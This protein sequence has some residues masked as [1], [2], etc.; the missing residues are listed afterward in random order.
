MRTSILPGPVAIRVIKRTFVVPKPVSLVADVVLR[1]PF[2]DLCLLHRITSTRLLCSGPLVLPSS[3][4]SIAA[5]TMLATPI[6]PRQL[7]LASNSTRIVLR[8]CGPGERGI[9][10]ILAVPRL[11]LPVDRTVSCFVSGAW[12]ARV[13]KEIL[14][15]RS[16]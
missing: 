10:S 5:H 13:L 16:F 4:E 2:P 14:L 15:V 8:G 7:L 12:R 1:L 11:C 6:V 3:S 9:S